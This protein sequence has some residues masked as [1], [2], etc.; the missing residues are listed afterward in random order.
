MR[1]VP[2]PSTGGQ[3]GKTGVPEQGR[4]I[5]RARGSDWEEDEEECKEKERKKG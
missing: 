5:V 4:K 3:Q 1:L 2:K